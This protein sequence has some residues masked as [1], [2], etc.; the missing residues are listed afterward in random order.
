MYACMCVC[1]N[2]NLWVCECLLHVSV[3]AY[4][5]VRTD[6]VRELLKTQPSHGPKKQW[7]DKITSALQA[8]GVSGD[9]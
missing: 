8:I 6:Q 3:C 9:R 5:W 1:V 7:R 4:V 2:V